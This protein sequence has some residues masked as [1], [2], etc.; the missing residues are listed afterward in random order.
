MSVL[1]QR[2]LGAD[3]ES[4]YD[5]VTGALRHDPDVIL[6]GEMRDPDTIRA[7]INAA[8]TGHL[9]IS[10][11]HANTAAEVVN[12]VISFFDP[13]ERDLVKLQLRD[14]LKCVINQRLVPR[15]GG[16]RVP[17][18]E[19]MMNDVKAI[20]DGIMEGSTDHIRIG[21]QQTVSQSFLFEHYLHR[22]FKEG[23]VD[24]EHAQVFATDQS[25]FDQIRMG[26]YAIPRLE[27]VRGAH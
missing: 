24:L 1:S 5:A 19:M 17:A 11:L 9:V 14:S 22:L 3:V 13:V 15:I 8:A 2:N 10:T 12:R 4:F 23:T 27:A 16:G 21:M 20:A 6:I 26:T 25:M 18:L 7:A